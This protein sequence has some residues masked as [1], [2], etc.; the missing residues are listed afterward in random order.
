M[1][2]TACPSLIP[3]RRP[4]PDQQTLEP[5]PDSSP[6][7]PACHTFGRANLDGTDINQKFITGA[8]FACG[9]GV[10]SGGQPPPAVV[11]PSP[12]TTPAPVVTPPPA[13]TKPSNTSLPT[14]TG[15]AQD[16]SRLSASNGTWSGSSPIDYRYQWRLCDSLGGGCTD[17][18]GQT[19]QTYVL[20]A[21]D[22]GNTLRV[23]VTAKNEAGSSLSVSAPTAK[24][25]AAASTTTPQPQRPRHPP[26]TGTVVARYRG[27]AGDVHLQALRPRRNRKSFPTSLRP[28]CELPPFPRT[29]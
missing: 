10:N 20:T 24:V 4:E 29:G 22:V 1:C 27:R 17:I 16:G 25:S 9:L 6:E 11:L 19:A 14:I 8:N 15:R 26:A 21:A 23:W 12:V 3:P 18:T 28:S 5:R 2:R 7:A 13:A